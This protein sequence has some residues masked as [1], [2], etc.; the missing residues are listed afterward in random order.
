M[1]FRDGFKRPQFW[2]NDGK[3][4]ISQTRVSSSIHENAWL[5]H[6]S[7]RLGRRLGSHTNPLEIPVDDTVGM[8]ITEPIND[9]EN[10]TRV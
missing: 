4:K 9:I 5:E 8:E 1:A 10:L 2:G 7:A 6:P 3:T